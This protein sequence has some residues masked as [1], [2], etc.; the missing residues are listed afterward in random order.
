[1]MLDIYTNEGLVNLTVMR[2]V[3]F[4]ITLRPVYKKFGG[5][6]RCKTSNE[7]R[8]LFLFPVAP[9]CSKYIADS[10]Q[11]LQINGTI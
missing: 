3:P 9:P 8:S 6:V 11:V 5:A 4:K 10:H 2:D 1:M 7:K